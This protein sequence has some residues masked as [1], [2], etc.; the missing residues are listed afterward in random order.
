MRKQQ[1][2]RRVY[3][4]GQVQFISLGS[5]KGMV[6]RSRFFKEMEKSNRRCAAI[7]VGVAGIYSIKSFDIR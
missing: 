1:I 2:D 6:G 4:A 7:S 3:P 5:M